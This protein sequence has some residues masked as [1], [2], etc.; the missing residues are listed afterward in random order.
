MSLLFC[1]I[2]LNGCG[3]ADSAPTTQKTTKQ[4]SHRQE[5][6]ITHKNSQ[7]DNSFEKEQGENVLMNSTELEILATMQSKSVAL[8]QLWVGTFQ[9][10]WNDLMNEVIKAPFIAADGNTP[11]IVAQL[12]KQSFTKSELADSYYYIQWGEASQTLK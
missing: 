1:G 7:P 4:T 9:L 6:L 5:N 8:N 3:V 10:V 2:W 11:A 12:N